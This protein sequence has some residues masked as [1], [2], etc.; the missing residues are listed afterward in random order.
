[1]AISIIG[2]EFFQSG[3]NAKAIQAQN[4]PVL[5]D[6]FIIGI[7]RGSTATVAPTVPT[8]GNATYFSAPVAI[9]AQATGNDSDDC[10]MQLYAVECIA[11]GGNA[12]TV[13]ANLAAATAGQSQAYISFH[14]RGVDYDNLIALTGGAIKTNAA[15]TNSSVPNGASVTPTVAGS[16][17]GVFGAGGLNSAITAYTKPADL[18]ATANHWFQGAGDTQTQRVQIGAGWKTDWASGAFDPA[19]FGG[20][21]TTARASWCASTLV[22]IPSIPVLQTLTGSPTIAE[23][24]AN[25]ATVGTPVGYTAG[26]TKSLSDDAG[27]R[28]AINSSTGVITVANGS[29]LNY[30]ANTTHNITIVETLAGATGSPK[31]T[32]LAVTITNRTQPPAT[33]WSPSGTPTIATDAAT[34]TLV[35]S[36]TLSDIFFANTSIVGGTNSS[37][38][39]LTNEAGIGVAIGVRTTTTPLTV[40]TSTIIVAN[41][42]Q[43]ASGTEEYREDTLSI[44]VTTAGDVLTSSNIAAP[45]PEITQS[46]ITQTHVLIDVDIEAPTPEIQQSTLGQIHTLV[47]Q[48]IATAT[49]VITAAAIG[50]IFALTSQN[51]ETSTPEIA[52]ST[53]TQTHTISTSALTT[54]TPEIS[55]SIVGQIHA[56][57]SANLITSTPEITQSSLLVTF[58]LNSQNLETSLPNITVSALGQSHTL[59]SLNIATPTSVITTSILAQTHALG[60]LTL[61]APTPEITQAV[62]A[63]IHNIVST[64]ISAQTPAI[65]SAVIGQTHILNSLPIASGTPVVSQSSLVATNPDNLTAQNITTGT[66]SI[67]QSTLG[68]SHALASAPLATAAPVIDLATLGQRHSLASAPLATAAPALSF[69]SLGQSHTLA[70]AALATAG[71]VIGSSTLGQIHAL[72]SASLTAPMPEISLS[73]LASF[74]TFNLV[75]TDISTSTPEISQS[76]LF[77]SNVLIPTPVERIFSASFENRV[78]SLSFE[79]RV[80]AIP[81]ENRR[82]IAGFENRVMKG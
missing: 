55:T 68:Q 35:G 36:L 16:W 20:G 76:I 19:A 7:G 13:V 52:Q 49:P 38:F 79:N 69:A 78:Y 37:E 30:E 11:N 23:N 31:S 44:T 59:S 62:L 12:A 77:S 58:T 24:A 71:P 21:T 53:I 41:S 43:G 15:G 57:S 18:S 72:A 10:T 39:V 63:Q 64:N 48:A 42:S 67:T 32:T 33:D 70:S 45:T 80:Y 65:S 2:G 66:P 8:Q 82:L 28:F 29:L 34:N 54:A 3:I 27:G 40:G 1:M 26:S 50:T 25:G 9:G 5:N 81:F 22:V 61:S 47:S 56:L 74:T 75:S 14:M 6:V 17:I 60:S 46:V 51:I 73:D 4:V